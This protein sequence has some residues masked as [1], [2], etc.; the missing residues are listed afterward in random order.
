MV[1][2]EM[3]ALC[4]SWLVPVAANDDRFFCFHGHSMTFNVFPCDEHLL[5][6]LPA[7]FLSLFFRFHMYVVCPSTLPAAPA[8]DWHTGW[9]GVIGP[10]G[11]LQSS[12]WAPFVPAFSVAMVPGNEPFFLVGALHLGS[13]MKI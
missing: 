8:R 3:D 7:F 12:E 13:K 4:I 11:L 5:T 6:I 2:C 1:Q 10:L 9:P